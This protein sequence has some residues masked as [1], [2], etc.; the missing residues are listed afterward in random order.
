MHQ[1]TLC[2]N[3]LS[4]IRPRYAPQRGA[5]YTTCDRRLEIAQG[6]WS[7]VRSC[8]TVISLTGCVCASESHKSRRRRVAAVYSSVRFWGRC[9]PPPRY[10]WGFA[11]FYSWWFTLALAW[12]RRAYRRAVPMAGLQL[13]VNPYA[14]GVPPPSVPSHRISLSLS[15]D[16]LA[17]LALVVESEAFRLHC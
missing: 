13:V 6:P 3:A 1:M 11:K 10:C 12:N 14:V 17:S 2:Y 7:C 9:H 5:R 8:V 4:Q 15:A 16:A